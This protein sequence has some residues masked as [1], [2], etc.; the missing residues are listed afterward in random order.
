MFQHDEEERGLQAVK[1]SCWQS[2]V[3]SGSVTGL[4]KYSSQPLFFFPFFI[5]VW[6]SLLQSI[7]PHA[8]LI[9]G[10]VSGAAT[11]VL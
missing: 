1:G 8:G 10:V 4:E 6:P 3:H 7:Y 5:S 2:V 11:N 9:L